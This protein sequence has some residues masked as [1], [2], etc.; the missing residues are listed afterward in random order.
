M[1]QTEIFFGID[2]PID[3]IEID[4]MNYIFLVAKTFIWKDKRLGKPCTMHDFLEY[5][6]EQILIETSSKTFKIRP[7]L[8]Y[9]S[10]RLW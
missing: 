4:A 5:L 6:H 3:T 7:F 1:S 8:I 10:E 9:L 2:N